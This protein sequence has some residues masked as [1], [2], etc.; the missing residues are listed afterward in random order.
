[1]ASLKTA[2]VIAPKRDA[3]APSPAKLHRDVAFMGFAGFAF[4]VAPA[5]FCIDVALLPMPMAPVFIRTGAVLASP[6]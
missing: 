2:L 4:I 1:M 3:A 5:G 6:P